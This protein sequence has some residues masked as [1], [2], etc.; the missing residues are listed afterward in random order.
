M[1]RWSRRLP[2]QASHSRARLSSMGRPCRAE[3][4]T[5]HIPGAECGWPTALG[6]APSAPRRQLGRGAGVVCWQWLCSRQLPARPGP[7]KT[8]AGNERCWIPVRPGPGP[9]AAPAGSGEPDL[10][11]L[12]PQLGQGPF[13]VG[14]PLEAARLKRGLD[15]GSAPHKPGLPASPCCRVCSEHRRGTWQHDSC[16]WWWLCKAREGTAC[17][18]PCGRPC[19]GRR[20]PFT[21]WPRSW[22]RR[23]RTSGPL[24]ACRT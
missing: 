7:I 13:R 20:P 4:Q 5:C 9:A 6:A 2:S 12:G 16:G 11:L 17:A 8:A 15:S 18:P 1:R 23:Q 3:T 10:G 21:Q 24:L 19:P 14:V 22:S